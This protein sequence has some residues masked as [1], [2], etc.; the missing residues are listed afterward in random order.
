MIPL[1]TTE[2]RSSQP[3][4]GCAFR[5]E[6]RPWVAQRVCPTPVVA[7]ESSS[8]ETARSSA[9]LPTARISST[10]PSISDSPAES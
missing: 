4:S 6:G 7:D 1:R 8:A 2:K 3:V 5:S 9:S 10:S